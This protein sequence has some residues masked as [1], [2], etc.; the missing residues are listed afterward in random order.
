M[1]H[2]SK[3]I[4][5]P[6]GCSDHDIVAK[7]RKAKV[8]MVGPKVIHK[9]SFNIFSQDSFVKD[10]KHLLYVGLMYMRKGIQKQH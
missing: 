7:T 10:V 2:F 6:I 4:A 8:P 1:L 3:N 5:V 9:R